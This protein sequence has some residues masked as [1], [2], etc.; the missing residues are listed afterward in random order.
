MTV[1]WLWPALL[2]QARASAE[3]LPPPE[4]CASASAWALFWPSATWARACASDRACT[5][6]RIASAAP[7]VKLRPERG[8]GERNAAVEAVAALPV[9]A[10]APVCTTWRATSARDVVPVIA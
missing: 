9:L 4:A 10:A 3:A 7:V 6:L 1:V 2:L 8:S 5:R